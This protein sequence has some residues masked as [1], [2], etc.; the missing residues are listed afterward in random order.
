MRSICALFCV[1]CALSACGEEA[2]T[3][4]Q[5]S[6]VS[7]IT[8]ANDV[9]IDDVEDTT[10]DA[11]GDTS[12]ILA[13][14]LPP[15]GTG[16]DTSL[17]DTEAEDIAEDVALDTGLADTSL[18]DS[19]EDIETLEDS[20][21]EA[22]SD[23]GVEDTGQPLTLCEQYCILADLNC[24]GENAIDFGPQ[25]CLAQ[26][27]TWPDGE[28]GDMD[29]DSVQCRLYHLGAAATDPETHCP[30]ASPDGGGVCVVPDYGNDA[31]NTCETAGIALLSPNINSATTAGQTN[32]YT[33][34]ACGFTAGTAK[35]VAWIL[36][37]PMSGIYTFNL[38]P[39]QGGPTVLY[40]VEDCGNISGTCAG[41]MN[42][43]VDNN[44]QAML[45]DMCTFPG[46][47]RGR[48]RRFLRYMQSQ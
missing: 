2:S 32:A 13:G 36:S 4:P 28:P 12:D 41:F 43:L 39:K 24:V 34:G 47:R 7:D 25:P 27:G 44:L 1:L 40:V 18:L 38:A 15:G 48:M 6:G 37:P 33:S 9:T 42:G 26:C 31:G 21:V 22:D 14:E 3:G 23:T 30:Y 11:F 20:A 46:V 16:A 5:D 10:T 29:G 35:D 17:E 8:F 19:A 45:T